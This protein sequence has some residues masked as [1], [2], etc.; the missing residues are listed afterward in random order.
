[1]GAWGMLSDLAKTGDPVQQRP[2]NGGQPQASLSA[3]KCRVETRCSTGSW[4]SLDK[5]L[6]IN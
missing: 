5:Y 6:L 3:C 4:Q 2:D 1:M